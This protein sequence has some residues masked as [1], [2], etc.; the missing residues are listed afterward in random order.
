MLI[1][2]GPRNLYDLGKGSTTLIEDEDDFDDEV[3][4]MDDADVAVIDAM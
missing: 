1:L 4:E 2:V 3:D